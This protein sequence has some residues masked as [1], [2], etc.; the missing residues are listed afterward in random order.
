MANFRERFA[1]L[2]I[3]SKI[4]TAFLF[5]CIVIAFAWGIARIVFKETFNTIEVISRPNPKLTI[6]N[7]L[8]QKIQ[9]IDYSQKVQVL[10]V[11]DNLYSPPV[12]DE[13]EE[14]IKLL[15]TLKIYCSN[16][17]LKTMKIERMQTILY[18]REELFLSYLKYR[19]SI[20]KN[21][22]L[23]KDIQDLSDYIARH[24]KK[25]DS[26]IV[27]T[28]I[29]NTTTTTILNSENSE[30]KTDKREPFLKRMFSRKKI[31]DEAPE[32]ATKFITE[33]IQETIDTFAVTQRDSF[34]KDMERAISSIEKDRFSRRNKLINH[35]LKLA[36]A[37]AIFI[38]ELE[39]LLRQ[40]QQEEIINLQASTESLSSVFNNAFNWVEIILCGFLILILILIFLIFSDISHSNKIK[41]QL[42]EAKEK[43][44][45]LEQVKHR[46][47]ANMSHE[48]R[49]PL[50]AIIGYSEL[51]KDQDNPE[52]QSLEAIHR[53]SEHLLQIVNE[54]LD[55]SRIISGKFV[56]EAR[57]FDMREVVADV[58]DIM[59][60]QA[61]KKNVLFKLK[62]DIP[63]DCFYSGDPFRLKQILF[64]L[65]GNAIKFTDRGEVTFVVNSKNS[66]ARKTDFTFEV[67]DTGIGMTEEELKRIFNT[68]EQ[69]GQ[70]IQRQFGGT[71]LG[72][73]IAKKLIVMQGGSIQV[74]SVKNK[75]SE[76]KVTLGYLKSA[77]K[78]TPSDNLVIK[79]LQVK[80][81]K[82]LVVDDDPFILQ[83]CSTLLS[84]HTI[85]H[86]CYVSSEQVLKDPWDESIN[87]V[88]LD[89]RMPV[90]NGIELFQ[91]LKK[92]AGTQ[93]RF[94]ALTAQA[95]PDEKNAILEHGFDQ[96]LLKPFRERELLEVIAQSDS[97]VSPA[98]FQEKDNFDL[99]SIEKMCMNDKALVEKT[100]FI[101]SKETNADLKN[102]TEAVNSKNFEKIAESCH[103]LSSKVGQ[104]GLLSLSHKLRGIEHDARKHQ[105]SIYKE[106]MLTGVLREIQEFVEKVEH[107]AVQFRQSM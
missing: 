85:E 70:T 65:L 20:Q 66:G 87:M 29:K 50:Q 104:A 94:V 62:C 17:T 56:F 73:S 4:I 35:E 103:K 59:E 75:G 61:E 88:L 34:I 106:Y 6:I 12:L 23:S 37:S 40:V 3:R 13:S 74:N 107:Y 95:L 42:I 9:R 54:V 8:F 100:L 45:H 92:V 26:S 41:A 49:T 80:A 28:T 44:E 97:R 33:N 99:S 91:R 19:Y 2:S 5:G 15:D 93:V 24:L 69:A 98:G 1:L 11:Q 89:I 14:I 48:I 25:E 78:L 77:E 36:S 67:K 83:L 7:T 21:N 105:T 68:F 71:G 58:A 52:K 10:K 86:T 39:Q 16:D 79:P 53:S 96:I 22:P 46:F 82:I 60:G 38:G 55:Y 30:K 18:E 72:L 51:V 102:L 31:Q 27:K 90:V 101:L 81:G 76:F 57:N 84:K 32:G 43:A 64:N 47:L 63:G